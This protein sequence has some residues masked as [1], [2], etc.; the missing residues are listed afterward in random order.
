MLE[1]D[2]RLVNALSNLGFLYVQQGKIDEAIAVYERAAAVHK[3]VPQVYANLAH[4]FLLKGDPDGAVEACRKALAISDRFALA[5]N[6]LARAYLQ[7]GERDAARNHI[8]KALELGFPVSEEL[9]RQAACGEGD[10]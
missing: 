7:R 1:I 2:P 10:T 3:N 9:Q 8:R 6:H 5:H 4:A